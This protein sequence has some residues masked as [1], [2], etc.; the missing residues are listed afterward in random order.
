MGKSIKFDN[1]T[2]IDWS[3]VA[4][5]NQGRNLQNFLQEQHLLLNT[6]DLTTTT[7]TETLSSSLYGYRLIC[8]VV[9]VNNKYMASVCVPRSELGNVYIQIPIIYDDSWKMYTEIK[10][11]DSTTIEQTVRGIKGWTEDHP[12]RLT[13]YGIL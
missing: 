13:I 7:K 8:F 12:K 9:K 11:I 5:D 4:V 2:Y 3:G 10:L 6:T 1:N